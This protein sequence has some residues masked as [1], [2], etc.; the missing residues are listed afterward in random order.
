MNRLFSRLLLLS[1][2]AVAG[3]G[4]QAGLKPAAAEQPSWSK[5][6]RYLQAQDLENQGKFV[7]AFRQ[8]Q[9]LIHGQVAAGLS[10]AANAAC[11]RLVRQ[12]L[13]L[14]GLTAVEPL[15]GPTGQEL[16]D[17]RRLELLAAS[18]DSKAFLEG[19][20]AF[21]ARFPASARLDAAQKL[22]GQVFRRTPVEAHKIGLLAPLS[23]SS[24]AFGQEVQ[25]GAELALARVNAA[26]LEGSKLVLVTA[27]EGG[28]SGTAMASAERLIRDEKVVAILGPVLS[29]A[30]Q[31]VAPIC[32]KER[33]PLFSP[34]ASQPGL[35]DGNAFFFRNALAADGQAGQ[36]ADF[37]ANSLQ[38]RRCAA[39]YPDTVSGQTLAAAF[40]HKLTSLGGVMAAQV[41]YAAG[42]VDFKSQLLDLGG[43]N[44]SIY[45]DA[46]TE[47]RNQL[48]AEVE[49]S[50]STLGDYL[51]RWMEAHPAPT[52]AP[53]S[54]PAQGVAQMPTPTPGPVLRVAV[55]DFSADTAAAMYNA[56]R[57]LSDR[58]FHTLDHL[59][60]KGVEVLPPSQAVEWLAGHPLPA[61]GL[62]AESAVALAHSLEVPLLVCGQVQEWKPDLAG[63]KPKDQ[64]HFAKYQVFKVEADVYEGSAGA[65]VA[66]R[67]FEYSKLRPLTGNAMSLQALYLPCDAED[68]VLI[69][70]NLPF[71]DLKVPLLGSSGWY[72]QSLL[73]NPDDLEGAHFDVS[74]FADNPGAEVQA[75]LKGY[76][77]RY[78]TLPGHEALGLAAQAYDAAGILAKVLESASNREDLRDGLEALRD[79]PG[80]TGTTSFGPV[81]DAV[82]K[83]PVIEVRKGAL[84]QIN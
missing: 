8:Y 4:G 52:A 10:A 14:G 35:T 79:Y 30:A 13:D 28:D 75:F 24:A 2:L 26:R 68:A 9:P 83:L 34:T 22:A 27:D 74:F 78:A 62:G 17:Y 38:A 45:K 33:V 43:I 5:D 69:A 37:A 29:R 65:V 48:Q 18:G 80:I 41:S 49:K 84:V 55:V 50:S 12:S 81:H 60:S 44:P 53:T 20:D 31:A 16:I 51:Q 25:R 40:A 47:A 63:L 70:P 7:E 67:H 54:N 46:E 82:K 15:V 77:D 23:G 56:G 76:K 72:R 66:S 39:L 32:Q 3:C 71:Y 42:T 59:S 6:P 64:E 21:K 61:T 1:V 73:K 57:G 19:L 36:M 11:N 58:F